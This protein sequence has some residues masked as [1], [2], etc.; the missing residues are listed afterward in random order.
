MI[1]ILF[2]NINPVAF[3]IFNFDIYWYSF[4]YIFGVAIGYVLLK[5]LNG[6]EKNIFSDKALDDLIFFMVI[7]IIV[8]ARLGSVLFFDYEKLIE[9][10]LM[11]FEVRKGGLSFHGGVLGVVL[12]IYLLCRKHKMNFFAAGDLI[13]CVAP[14]GLFLGRIAN[15]V[16]G[17][18]WGRV[19]DV[20]WGVVF[21]HAGSLPRHPSQIYE[22]ALEG[23]L[24]FAILMYLHS[25][26]NWRRNPGRLSGA[27]LFFYGCFRFAV[28]FVREPDYPGYVLN[29]VT[30]AQLLCMPMI[31][32]GV[33]LMCRKP[34]KISEEDSLSK[35]KQ[36]VSKARKK[37]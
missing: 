30:V 21:P 14:I 27:F 22:A 37:S 23:I 34:A 28:E 26:P 16:N 32:L 12:A 19:T 6:K 24:L 13:A 1:A 9:R 35:Q 15:F 11:I 7:G 4:A 18:L 17:E 25:K 10:P 36:R 29:I 3:R 31:G 20:P 8:G 2:P 5:Y 33:Y